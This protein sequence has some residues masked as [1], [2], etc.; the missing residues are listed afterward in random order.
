[1]LSYLNRWKTL[2]KFLFG[3]RHNYCTSAACNCLVNKITE[4]FGNY[5]IA[6][7]VVV[8]FYFSEAFDILDHQLFSLINFITMGFAVYRALGLEVIW[9]IGPKK[10]KSTVKFPP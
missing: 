4:R 10:S 8:F 9:Q 5:K 2:Q 3:S 1:M 6:S 7:P